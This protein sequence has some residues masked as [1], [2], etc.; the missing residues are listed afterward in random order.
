MKT[1]KIS[2]FKNLF[3]KKSHSFFESLDL[4]NLLK[5]SLEYSFFSGGKRLR[6]WIIYNIGRYYDIDEEKLLKIGFATEIIHTAS[7]IHDDLPAID[8]SNYRRG[9]MSNHKKFSEWRAILTGDLGFILPFK[10]FAEFDDNESRYL[11]AFFSETILNLIEGETLD[12]A[13]EKNIIKPTKSDIENMYRKKTSA[14]FEFSFACSPLL[15]N[16]KEEFNSLKKAGKN[17]GIA[18]QIYD[19]LKDIY[20]NFEDV[21]KDL[22]RDE[23]KFTFL[24]ILSPEKAKI[25]ANNL[26]SETISILLSLKFI[27]FIEEL[28]KIKSLIERK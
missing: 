12:V 15:L 14:L 22:N 21:G 19:D 5:T 13:F 20:G 28:Q 8:N 4:S 23:N 1:M 9:N 27:D 18:F 26:F 2:D 25:Y 3:D 6:P 10:I 17:F 11:N 16:K 7:L 24:K